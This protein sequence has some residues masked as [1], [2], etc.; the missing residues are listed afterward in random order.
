MADI[1][2]VQV[3]DTHGYLKPHPELFW[4]GGSVR[5]ETLG[6]YHHIAGILNGSVMRGT[7]FSLTAVTPSMAHTMP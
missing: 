5:Y 3:N 4:E 7:P 6:G 1:S 2:I